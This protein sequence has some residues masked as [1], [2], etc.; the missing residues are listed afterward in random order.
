[1]DINKLKEAQQSFERV[2]IHANVFGKDIRRCVMN[3]SISKYLFRLLNYWDSFTYSSG[4]LNNKNS[5]I[6]MTS[7]SD[8][9]SAINDIFKNHLPPKEESINAKDKKIVEEC[10]RTHAFL[11]AQIDRIYERTD[12]KDLKR[13]VPMT[14]MGAL[15]MLLLVQSRQG[16]EN[17]LKLNRNGIK[18]TEVFVYL[19]VPYRSKIDARGDKR[20]D[21]VQKKDSGPIIDKREDI[22]CLL[23]FISDKKQ[24][25]AFIANKLNTKHD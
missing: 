2:R 1:M 14:T 21:F 12:I 17:T 8:K 20:I 10:R 18:L 25:E 5:V 19:K 3:K 23:N 16:I 22:D 4:W 24:V 13:V 9:L 6:L 7:V 11:T 15:E